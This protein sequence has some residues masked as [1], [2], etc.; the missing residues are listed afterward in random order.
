MQLE[1]SK[2]VILLLGSLKYVIIRKLIILQ[3]LKLRTYF[4]YLSHEVAIFLKLGSSQHTI[5]KL[6]SWKCS[7]FWE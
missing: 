4:L 3:N 1:S 5:S 7:R 2:C 6:Q